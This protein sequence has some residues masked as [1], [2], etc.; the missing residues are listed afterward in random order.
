MASGAASG[1]ASSKGGRRRAE[2][3]V[4]AVSVSLAIAPVFF[5]CVR[6]TNEKFVF[7]QVRRQPPT[8]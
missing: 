7:S 1:S 4:E 8:L 5:S 2:P 6:L 3:S